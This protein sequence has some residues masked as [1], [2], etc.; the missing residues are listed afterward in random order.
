MSIVRPRSAAEP[1]R[2]VLVA[3]LLLLLLLL[4]QACA[5]PPPPAPSTSP[6]APPTAEA[7]ALGGRMTADEQEY[8]WSALGRLNLA[9]QGFCTGVLVGPAPVLPQARCL[10][11]RPQRRGFPPP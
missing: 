3:S 11:R 9:G 4:L 7:A 1:W 10:L 6:P 2:L 8:P 5:A